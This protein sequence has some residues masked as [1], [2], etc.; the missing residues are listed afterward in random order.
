[1][2]ASGVFL[3]VLQ[4][5]PNP[6]SPI[7]LAALMLGLLIII[8][9]YLFSK[10]LSSPQ[11]E[12]FAREEFSQFIFTIL[13][14]ASFGILYVSLSGISSAAICGTLDPPCDHM[15]VALYSLGLVRSLMMDTYFSLYAYEVV[16][17]TF[18]TMGFYVPILITPFFFMW[19]SI[20]PLS[21]LEPL[22]NALVTVIESMGYLVGLAFGRERL[23]YFFRDITP[24][25]LAIGFLMRTMPF[26]RKTGSSIIAIV[27]A[28][29]FAYPLSIILSHY[30]MFGG[31][32]SIKGM[33]VVEPPTMPM[34]CSLSADDVDAQNRKI[35]EDW[36]ELIGNRLYEDPDENIFEMIIGTT[37]GLIEGVYD[38]FTEFLP[39]F[40][41]KYN[42]NLLSPNFMPFIHFAYFFITSRII[43]LAQIA[44]LVLITFVFEVLLTVTAFR[45]VSQV[46]GGE[47]EILGLTMVA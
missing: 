10:F 11:L 18:S 43:S 12:A 47:I 27:F 20:Q 38:L 4:A 35:G 33:D 32:L 41:E 23:I 29:F 21:G 19:T 37:I 3:P 6:V 31:D 40:I 7:V 28:G 5:V 45:S 13:I 1:M 34:M 36:E 26:S 14:F 15:D 2:L 42:F 39:G 24:T 17:G 9:Y 16:I 44:I 46:L 30:M 22:S 8:L 25:L